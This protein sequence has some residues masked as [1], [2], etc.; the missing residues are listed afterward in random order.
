MKKKYKFLLGVIVILLI[1]VSSLF[2]LPMLFKPQESEP[3][4][5]VDSIDD[6]S[7]TLEDRDTNL[8]KDVYNELKVVL[9]SEEKDMEAYAGL[10]TKLFIIDLFTLDNKRN[11]YDVGSLEFVYPDAVSNYKLNVQDT[12]YKSLMN[13][14]L[15]KRKQKLPIV[16]SVSIDSIKASK[17]DLTDSKT[18]DAYEVEVSWGYEQDSGYDKQA[19]VTCVILDEK[20]YVAQYKTGEKI[21]E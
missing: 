19:K 15:G 10:I 2:F 20:I 17:F 6:F 16:S 21:E 4:K 13:N 11:R 3:I 1:I 7:Y 12:L 14:Q 8:M 9:K 5:V 18:L